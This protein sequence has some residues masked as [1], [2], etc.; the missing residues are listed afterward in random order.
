[1]NGTFEPS[2]FAAQPANVAR[3]IRVIGLAVECQLSCCTRASGDKS[4]HQAIF[5]IC[6][7]LV[8]GLVV[9]YRMQYTAMVEFTDQE[10]ANTANR[11]RSWYA[12]ARNM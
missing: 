9:T 3:N 12:L 10:L 8:A 4:R 6:D 7:S 1:M 11:A 2:R 5:V